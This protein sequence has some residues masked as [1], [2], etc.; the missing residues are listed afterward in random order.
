[1]TLV[2]TKQRKFFWMR[3]LSFTD[4]SSIT[5]PPNSNLLDGA[6]TFTDGETAI[7]IPV[8]YDS[9]PAPNITLSRD[10]SVQIDFSR[11]IANTSGIY[12]LT[13]TRSD[14][15]NYTINANHP[16]AVRLI[17]FM[18]NVQ[19]ELTQLCMITVLIA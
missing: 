15:A 18:I 6:Y 13:I 19:C 17:P 10:G 8:M 2:I 9:N 1:M 11:V 3:F 4:F 14:S 5:L 12:F 16:V 7:M